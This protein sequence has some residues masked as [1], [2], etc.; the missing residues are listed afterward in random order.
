MRAINTTTA[1]KSI[2]LIGN[3]TL[4]ERGVYRTFD[5]FS[6]GREPLTLGADLTAPGNF[7]FAPLPVPGR[8]IW[9]Q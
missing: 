9:C 4:L 6:V 7:G 3:L 2:G 8:V 1:I 5:D